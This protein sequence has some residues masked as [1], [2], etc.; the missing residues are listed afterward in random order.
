[1]PTI[2]ADCYKFTFTL[3]LA[4]SNQGDY[5]YQAKGTYSE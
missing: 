5:Q 1:M 4:I 2:L 3:N